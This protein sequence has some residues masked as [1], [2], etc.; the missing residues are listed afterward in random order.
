MQVIAKTKDGVLINATEK[1]VKEILNA[2]T[3]EKPKELSIGQRI[4]AIDYASTI[5]KIKTLSE[6]Y[7]YREM[8]RYFEKFTKDIEGLTK[9]IESTKE[10]SL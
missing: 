7:N 3:G 8:I 10:I 6:E 4:P 2:V 5:T 9:V 1:E